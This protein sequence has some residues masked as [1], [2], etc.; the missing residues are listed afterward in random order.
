MASFCLLPE[1]VTAFKRALASHEI[2]PFKMADMESEARRELLGK[3][4]G[5]ENAKQV[6]SLFE[7]KLLLKNQKAGFISWAKQVGGITP[8]VRRDMLSRIERMD[9]VLN[10]GDEAQFLEDLAE[11]RLGIKITQEEAKTVS[12]LSTKVTDLKTKANKDGTFTSEKDRL[13]YGASKVAIEKYIND[14][15]LQSKS[16]SFTESP[17]RKTGE[18]IKEL[19]GAMKSIVAS[20][21]NSFWGRQGIKTL[22]DVRTSG[23]WFKNFVKSFSDI[24]K[25]LIGVDVIDAI[26]ADIYSRPNALNGKYDAG[27]YGLRV[28]TEEAYPSS[29][30]DKIPLLG[31][32][33]RASEAAYNGAALRLRADLADRLIRIAEK[34]GVN[35]LDKTQAEGMG[36]LISSL[37]GRGSYGKADVLAGEANVLFFSVKF[38]KSNFDTLTAHQF[39][40]KATSFTKKEAAK[41]L[42]SITATLVTV[43]TL[44]K[45]LDPESVEDDPRS[46]NFGKVRVFGRWTDITGGMAGLVTLA[47]RIVPTYHE[48]KLSFWTKNKSGI[49]TDLLEGK[50]G[51]QTALDVLEGFME[52]KL[53]PFAG[54]VRD[55][56]K[57]EDYQGNPITPESSFKKVTTP[58]VLQ[59]LEQLQKDKETGSVLGSLILD[60]LGLSVSTYTGNKDWNSNMTKELTQFKETVGSDTFEKANDIYN[61][62]YNEW[63]TNI[64]KS[65]RYKA[66]SDEGKKDLVSKAK[67]KIKDAIFES[68]G[69]TYKEEEKTKTQQK[70][71]EQIDGLL[72][73][74][75][76][77]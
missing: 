43:L 28:L 72:N 64:Q 25:S 39:D 73:R 23:I 45:L 74:L 11:S 48:G 21:D 24:G 18:F 51:G 17:I 57:G 6:N 58:I 59:N 68:Y 50:F 75:S 14:L 76:T 9:K 47:S 53:S 8:E 37:T 42:L 77:F 63:F 67:S 55:I 19:P 71:K 69:F 15:K 32:L 30:P 40:S 29:L 33:F 65:E 3:Y 22:L 27:N 34:Q 36:T 31:R 16:I 1:K 7:S 5:V 56:W 61:E 2:D 70:E 60:A 62:K 10:P 4:V 44:A 52:G 35:T 54:I 26:K 49:Y 66:L 13:E 41:N 38:L 20:I 12:D 46:T